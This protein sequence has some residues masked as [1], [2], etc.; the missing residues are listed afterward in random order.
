MSVYM[1]S[2]SGFSF[3]D[4]FFVVVLDFVVFFFDFLGVGD[5]IDDFG[6]VYFGE[7]FLGY[8]CLTGTFG[9]CFIGWG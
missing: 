1:S 4:P 8:F 9:F 6:T 3:E 5:F 2:S 7:V